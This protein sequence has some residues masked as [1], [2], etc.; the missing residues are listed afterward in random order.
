MIN[1]ITQFVQALTAIFSDE[2]AWIKN[3]GNCET[4][5]TDSFSFKELGAEDCDREATVKHSLPSAIHSLMRENGGNDIYSGVNPFDFITAVIQEIYGPTADLIGFNDAPY[6]NYTDLQRV[7]SLALKSAEARDAVIEAQPHE[8][9]SY[10]VVAAFWYGP[11]DR[12]VALWREALFDS[13]NEAFE[14]FEH[15]RKAF[16]R[17]EEEPIYLGTIE[18]RVKGIF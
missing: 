8:D 4:P 16:S 15:H 18:Y 7:L 12:R 3:S 14:A 13:P 1:N 9:V 6:T 5:L 17:E 2:G 10:A 11:N